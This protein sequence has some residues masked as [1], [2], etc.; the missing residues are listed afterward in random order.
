MFGGA[1]DDAA[2]LEEIR[3][4]VKELTRLFPLPS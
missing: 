1:H 2:A 4:K 3:G